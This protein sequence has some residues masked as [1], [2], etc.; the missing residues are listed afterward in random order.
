MSE[1]AILT[2]DVEMFVIVEID[3][4]TVSVPVSKWLDQNANK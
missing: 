1:E 2:E 4:E 3:G